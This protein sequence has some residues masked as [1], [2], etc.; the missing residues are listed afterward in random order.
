M[1]RPFPMVVISSFVLAASWLKRLIIVIP[2]QAHPFLPIQN[3][4]NEWF[5]YKPTLTETSIT[6]A[7]FIIVLIIITI[8]SKL[9]PVVPIW[10]MAAEEEQNKVTE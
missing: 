1:R 5:V 6:L 8:L 2:P 4:P 7:A 10:E 9:F 3:V